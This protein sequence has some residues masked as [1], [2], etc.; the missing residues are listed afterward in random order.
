[1]VTRP[2][3][4]A[5]NFCDLIERSGG[6]AVRFPTLEIRALDAIDGA[7]TGLKDLGRYDWLVFVSANAVYFALKACDNDIPVPA[8]LKVAAIGKSTAAALE[9]GGVSV[10]LAPEGRFNSEEFLA[11]PEMQRVS[12]Q[13][14]LIVRGQGGRE[15]LADTLQQRGAHV[16]YSEIYRRVRPV[17][18]IDHHLDC[19]RKECI[20]AVTIFSGESL[21]NFVAILGPEGL[22]WVRNV[23]LVVASARIA[24]QAKQDGFNKVI[25]ADNASDW[26]LFKAVSGIFHSDWDGKSEFDR[27][28]W[29]VS[30][31]KS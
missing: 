30:A 22:R 24:R 2:E 13:R 17:V 28:E 4:Q 6:K 25:L 7:F 29:I 23:P 1:M 15:K 14:F 12:G 8:H 21:S 18:D 19:W 26:A 9:Q 16:I 5:R 11:L 3:R 31:S 27:G 20:D 10:S